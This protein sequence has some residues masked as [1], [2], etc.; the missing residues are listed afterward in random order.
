[1]AAVAMSPKLCL[2]IHPVSGSLLNGRGVYC[3]HQDRSELKCKNED[4]SRK[5]HQFA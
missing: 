5:E 2:E 4:T 3:Q 1:M